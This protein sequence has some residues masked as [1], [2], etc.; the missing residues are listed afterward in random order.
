MTD[1]EKLLSDV[2]IYLV[3]KQ[4]IDEEFG[5]YG[6]GETEILISRL[7]CICEVQQTALDDDCFCEFDNIYEK[8]LVLRKQCVYC[9]AKVKANAIARG[10]T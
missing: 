2:R 6:P 1:V 8:P 4:L 7:V 3:N 10:E 5:D 9:A